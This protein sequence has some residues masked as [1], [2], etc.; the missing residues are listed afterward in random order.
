MTGINILT[1]NTVSGVVAALIFTAFSAG[2]VRAA[3]E[4]IVFPSQGQS[5]QQMEQDKFNCYQWAKG[6]TSFDPMQAPTA[7]APPEKKGGVLRGAAGGALAGAAVG[8]I[9]G[10]AG[11]G[12]AIGAASGGMI[13]GARRH[14]SD[15]AQQEAAQQQAAGYEQ[16]RATYNRAWSACM[17]GKGYTVK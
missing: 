2:S 5:D 14:R 8:A 7:A 16:Q 3:A 10:D 1:R 13:G 4:P 12:A 9:A 6:Q 15:Q 11:T 17:E